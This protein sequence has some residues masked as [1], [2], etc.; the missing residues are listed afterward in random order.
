MR[1]EA[2][3]RV[4]AAVAEP[5]TWSPPRRCRPRRIP[6]RPRRHHPPPDRDDLV[7]KPLALHEVEE[8]ETSVVAALPAP[9]NEEPAAQEPWWSSRPRDPSGRT[10]SDDR[11][12]ARKAEADAVAPTNADQRDAAGKPHTSKLRRH[13]LV[14]RRHPA[15]GHVHRCGRR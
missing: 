10:P 9:P 14:P 1:A 12:A 3:A 2:R 13:R 6:R 15:A 7:T 11:T 5:A 8:I 4:I